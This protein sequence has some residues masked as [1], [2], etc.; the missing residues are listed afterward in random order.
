[1]IYKWIGFEEKIFFATLHAR[2]SLKSILS[3]CYNISFSIL[4]LAK[5]VES[6]RQTQFYKF[7]QSM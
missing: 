2:E 4:N 5:S 1:M 3:S 6:Q 7:D